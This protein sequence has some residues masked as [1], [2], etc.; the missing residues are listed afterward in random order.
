M[1]L[2]MKLFMLAV[3]G[4]RKK[5]TENFGRDPE[6]ILDTKLLDFRIHLQFLGPTYSQKILVK[7][8]VKIIHKN[9]ANLSLRFG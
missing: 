5:L 2:Q 6:N 8:Y 7:T 9:I 1:V 3:P 4:Q